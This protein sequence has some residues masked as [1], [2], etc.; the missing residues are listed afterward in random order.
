METQT[1]I[2]LASNLMKYL[3]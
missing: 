3:R 2:T 1:K